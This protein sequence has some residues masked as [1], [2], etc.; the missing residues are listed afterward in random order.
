MIFTLS[1]AFGI[2]AKTATRDRCSCTARRV[3][4]LQNRLNKLY[5]KH[6]KTPNR[7]VGGFSVRLLVHVV[8]DRHGGARTEVLGDK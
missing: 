2:N 3:E 5:F 1:H 6:T 8:V 4:S 7:V